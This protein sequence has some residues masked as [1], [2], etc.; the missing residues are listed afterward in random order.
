[1]RFGRERTFRE[2]ILRLACLKPGESVLDMGS[3][4]GSLAIAAKR[5][6]E[7]A[8]I[9]QAIDA[10]PKILARAKRKAAGVRVDVIF[11][12]A[13]SQALPFPDA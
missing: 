10:S 8:G 6:V 3:G 2:K 13:P 7:S 9:V 12:E 4:T 11:R 1:M 5:H